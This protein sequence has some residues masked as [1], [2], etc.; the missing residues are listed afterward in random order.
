MLSFGVIEY[1]LCMQAYL[2]CFASEGSAVYVTATQEL[3]KDFLSWNLFC[4][5]SILVSNIVDKIVCKFYAEYY[6]STML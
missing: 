6:C 5:E 1:K 2:L 4:W 3:P